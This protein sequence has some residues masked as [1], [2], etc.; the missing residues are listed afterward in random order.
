MQWSDAPH[1]VFVVVL[2]VPREDLVEE[3]YVVYGYRSK[4][5]KKKKKS[6]KGRLCPAVARK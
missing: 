5:V 4:A 3:A 2:T 6:C 1:I